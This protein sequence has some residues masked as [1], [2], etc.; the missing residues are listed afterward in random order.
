MR[1]CRKVLI[2]MTPDYFNSEWAEIENIMAQTLSPANRDLQLI[3]L[4]KTKCDK[5]L[6]IAALTHIDFSADADLQLAW[7]QLLESLQGPDTSARARMPI[8]VSSP[9]AATVADAEP[10]LEDSLTI[11]IPVYNEGPILEDLVKALRAEGLLDKTLRRTTLLLSCRNALVTTPN[12]D[13]SE[14]ELMHV[15]WAQSRGWHRW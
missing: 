14:T 7:H 3:P 9:M 6:R 4:L 12:S 5:P 2:V 11:I 13:A 15:R 10:C 8:S 1:E